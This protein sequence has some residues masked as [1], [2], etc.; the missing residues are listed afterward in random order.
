MA[1]ETVHFL[2]QPEVPGAMVNPNSPEMVCWFVILC[3][4]R[5]DTCKQEQQKEPGFVIQAIHPA[6]C[7]EKPCYLSDVCVWNHQL[8]VSCS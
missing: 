1:K 7:N 6:A 3:L 4:T 2:T 8:K 5:G